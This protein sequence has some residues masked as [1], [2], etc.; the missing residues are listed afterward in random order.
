MVKTGYVEIKEGEGKGKR[1]FCASCGQEANKIITFE[2][3]FSKLKVN[4]CAA[5]ATKDYNKLKLQGKL[6]FPG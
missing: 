2:D 5:C 4:L 1:K 3:C 6:P